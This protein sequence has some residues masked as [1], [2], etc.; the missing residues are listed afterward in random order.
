MIINLGTK[1]IQTLLS[2]ENTFNFHL[3]PLIQGTLQKWSVLVQGK[4]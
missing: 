1:F 4:K 2:K 3:L